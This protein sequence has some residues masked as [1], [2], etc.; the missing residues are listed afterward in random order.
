MVNFIENKG[1]VILNR[2]TNGDEEEEFTYVGARGNSII[3]YVIVNEKMW[4][5]VIEFR[6]ENR[7]DSDHLPV[8]AFVVNIGNEDSTDVTQGRRLK[9]KKGNAA[10]EKQIIS[11]SEEDIEV[12]KAVTEVIESDEKEEDPV[13]LRWESLKKVI[14]NS[15]KRKTI[16]IKKWKIGMKSWWDHSC[17]RQKNAVNIALKKWKGGKRPKDIYL[18]KSREWRKHCCEKEQNF[19]EMEEA[20]LR[21]IRREQDVWKYLNKSRKK[22]RK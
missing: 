1:W 12:F 7:V 4:D 6:V 17:K 8:C 14:N 22:K 18:N 5:K 11:W 21:N 19:K 13:E 3:D 15:V 10:V 20:E 9:N 2:L 16:K